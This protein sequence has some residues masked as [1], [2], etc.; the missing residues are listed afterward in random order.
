MLAP[1]EVQKML[2]LQAL[3]WGAKRI[4][5]E[6][7]CSR[8]TVREYLR[9]GG[10]RPMRTAHREGVLEPHRQWLAERLRQHRGNADVVRQDLQ[11]ELGI[12]VSL[13]TVQRAV[14]PLRREL[15]RR[16]RGHGALRDGA[17]PAAANRL[18]QHV[19]RGRRRA[20]A[21]PPVRRHAGLQPALPRRRVPARASDVMAARAG[22]RL[23]ALRWRA[24]RG[25]AGQR[26]AAGHRAQRANARGPLQRPL[27]RV[28][29]LLGLHARG[30]ARPYRARPR[31]RTSAAS[32][33]SSA[34][35]S[36]DTA[37]PASRRCRHTCERWMREVA[38]VRIHG[39]T[40]E[41]PT[42]A[43][44][45]T[46]GAR[47]CRPL[48]VEGA[49]PSRCAS[50]RGACTAT[51]ASSWTPTATACRGGCI[52]ETVTVVVAERQVRV[53]YAGQEVACHAQSALRRQQRHRAQPPGGHRRRQFAGMTWLPAT[54]PP[55]SSPGAGASCS[56]RSSS[57]RPSP[58]GAGDGRVE[59][60]RANSTRSSRCSRGSSSPPSATSS[61]RC[62]TRPPGPS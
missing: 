55:P 54:M 1:Q 13:R 53:L 32:A 46:R 12:R 15:R 48:A 62:S 3:G 36:P 26:Q 60:D 21:H 11:R 58:E 34:T 56:A 35:P 25:P 24:A 49:V 30:P 41:P 29:P 44:R 18:R 28:L 10:W 57:T 52:G 5:R 16:E 17:G 8:N 31:A 40:G 27:P 22:R 4:S 2:A 23:P 14:E 47:R 39:S 50:S 37:S 19:G 33:T 38:D 45:A 43:L 9:Q 7:G 51:P 20:A 59:E 6:L 61:T 42:A